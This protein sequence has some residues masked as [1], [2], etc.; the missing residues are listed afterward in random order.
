MLR[1]F[2]DTFPQIT[3]P[4]PDRFRRNRTMK[5]G[6]RGQY[7]DARRGRGRGGAERPGDP[8]AILPLVPYLDT[9][10]WVFIAVALGASQS[11]S[12]PASM[13]GAG[14]GG[15]R[16]APGRVRREPMDAGGAALRSHRVP[17]HGPV[18]DSLRGSGERAG[19]LAERLETTEKINDVRRRMLEAAARRP[20]DRNELAERLRDRH[21]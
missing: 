20:R 11:R 6:G 2:R 8:T 1:L 5:S 16:R 12:T 21:F 13:T 9:L 17:S 4:H 18:P 3:S 15:D 14:G 7:G 19:R 10:R